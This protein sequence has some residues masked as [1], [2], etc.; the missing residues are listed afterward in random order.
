MF[1]ADG[2]CKSCGMP[3]AEQYG[4]LTLQRK[5]LS[6]LPSAWVP[7]WRFDAICLGE[8]LANE[9]TASFRVKYWPIAWHGFSPGSS[10]QLVIPSTDEPWFDSHELSQVLIAVHGTAGAKCSDCGK[11]RWMPLASEAL[12]TPIRHPSWD[13]FDIVASPEWFG[14]GWKSF[15]QIMVRRELA[16]LIVAAGPKDFAARDWV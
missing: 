9:V 13:E 1:G 14:D 11:W 3:L 4:P 6:K 15:R 5:G 8:S 12:P 10:V 7:N 2:W 16:E